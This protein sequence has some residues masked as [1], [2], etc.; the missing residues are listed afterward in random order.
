MSVFFFLS[1]FFNWGAYLRNG[2]SPTPEFSLS[3]PQ[4]HISSPQFLFSSPQFSPSSLIV[5]LSL[6][7]SI[8]S[9]LSAILSPLFSILSLLSSILSRFLKLFSP[10]FK[11]LFLFCAVTSLLDYLFLQSKILW[12]FRHFHTLKTTSRY[13]FYLQNTSFKATNFF[14]GMLMDGSHLSVIMCVSRGNRL[15]YSM[16]CKWHF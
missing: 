3:V 12:E 5:S 1:L 9:P 4:F 14:H 8:L 6:L 10:L 2:I 13:L 16:V 15:P 7:S 11:S